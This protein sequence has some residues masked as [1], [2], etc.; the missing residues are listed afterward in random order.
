MTAKTPPYAG[1]QTYYAASATAAPE[2]ETLTNN[3]YCD[4]CI[5]GAGF[6]GLSVGLELAEAGKSVVIL[7]DQRVG[8]GAS[9][10][11]GGQLI[12]GYSRSLKVIGKRYGP[13]AE[14][15]LGDMALEG[16]DII[17]SRVK[18]YAI[19][20]DLVDGGVV[21]ALTA[22]HMRDLEDHVDEWHRHG[23]SAP[24]MMDKAALQKMVSSDRYVGA[25]VDPR[26]GHF[27]PLNYLLGEAAAFESLGGR[28]Y[29]H[30]RALGIEKGT[31]PMA[32]TANGNVTA[33]TIIVCGNAYLGST[34][35]QLTSRIMPVSSQVIA[36][37]PLGN[38]AREL[39]PENHCVEDAN[40]ILDYFRRTAD[41]RILF[42]GGAVY[43]GLDPVSIEAKIRPNMLKTFPQLKNAR[44]DFAWSGNFALTLSRIPQIGRLT[45]NI[46]FSHGDS[47]HGV[48]TTQLLGRLVAEAICGD[49]VRFDHFASL[50]YFPF[51]GGRLL[52]VPFSTLGS[53]YYIARDHLGL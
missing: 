3:I 35:P 40:Y 17:R 31:T 45:P 51:P 11:N 4:A 8:W 20:C 46:Y 19:D 28:I 48:T 15:A 27:H 53:W 6:T 9:G 10:R 24:Y 47:G 36:T 44:I 25:M 14:R 1:M 18:K 38:L 26:S 22:K 39:I 30:S 13:G 33:E 2:R 42:G 41:G 21:T 43:G 49:T 37:E 23:H 7:E 50:P 32:H 12:N 16:S 52:R 5:I 34:V 29:E